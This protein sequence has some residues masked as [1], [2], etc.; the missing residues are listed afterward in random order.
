MKT[1]V[2]L[3]FCIKDIYNHYIQD[4]TNECQ[5]SNK[6]GLSKYPNVLKYW[7]T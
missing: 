7:D 6:M 4:E 1:K 5:A 2:S 3:L